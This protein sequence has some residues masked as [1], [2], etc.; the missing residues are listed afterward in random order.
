MSIPLSREQM[1]RL[2][3]LKTDIATRLLK[4]ERLRLPKE[5]FEAW[6][7]AVITEGLTGLELM[8]EFH[9]EDSAV[10]AH[11]RNLVVLLIAADRK[12]EAKELEAQAPRPERSP[13][14]QRKVD[15][16]LRALERL[17]VKV[18]EI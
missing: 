10:V 2:I 11:I 17:G 4:G 15:H 6:L 9:Y 3:A 7:T 18:I 16:H 8:R 14:Q 5:G 12:Q 13:G 1:G